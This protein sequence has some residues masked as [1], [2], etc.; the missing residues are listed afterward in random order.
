MQPLTLTFPTG[1]RTMRN[2]RQRGEMLTPSTHHD[3]GHISDIAEIVTSN[4]MV[5]IDR[6]APVLDHRYA[7]RGRGLRMINERLN[8]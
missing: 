3:I 7:T 5:S 2:C 1:L 8:A 4:V 6:D